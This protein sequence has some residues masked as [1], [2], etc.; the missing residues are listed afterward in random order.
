MRTS[1][2]AALAQPLRPSSSH[3]RSPR[4]AFTLPELLVI[5]A[6]CAVLAALILPVLLAPRRPAHRNKC[7]NNLKNIGLTHRIFA[8]DNGDRFPYPALSNQVDAA[9]FTASAYWLWLSN[10]LST[11]RILYCPSDTRRQATD[12]WTNLHA[13]NISYFVNL[14]ADETRPHTI[15]GGD[16]NLMM[17]G[18]PLP[19]GVARGTNL[20]ELGWGADIH[21]GQGYVAMSDGSV[22]QLSPH[23]LRAARTNFIH[24]GEWS[25][26]VP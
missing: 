21:N 13:T 10:E 16:R 20:A 22:Q 17:G 26:L 7:V 18:M 12:S 23:R 1:R 11:P 19:P 2:P 6:V 24:A 9:T 4:Q 25:L 8:T 3:N 5:V 15:L 14:H